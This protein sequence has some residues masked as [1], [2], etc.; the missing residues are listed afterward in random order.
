MDQSEW[1]SPQQII[2]GANEIERRVELYLGISIADACNLA[3]KKI[4]LAI[5]RASGENDAQA[6]FE[7]LECEAAVAMRILSGMTIEDLRE[8][9]IRPT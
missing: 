9:A 8:I 5:T 7:L 6:E 4:H 1:L 2:A 3:T